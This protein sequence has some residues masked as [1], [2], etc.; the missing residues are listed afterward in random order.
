MGKYF[1]LHILHLHTGKRSSIILINWVQSFEDLPKFENDVFI[2]HLVTGFVSILSQLIITVYLYLLQS[3]PR[4]QTVGQAGSL[5][6]LPVVSETFAGRTLCYHCYTE[7]E[8]LFSWWKIQIPDFQARM[9][10][11][12]SLFTLQLSAGGSFLIWSHKDL[13]SWPLWVWSKLSQPYYTH[14][15]PPDKCS[16]GFQWQLE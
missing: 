10:L 4:T 14:S 6:Q 1:L 9:A 13:Y 2:F 8:D 16:P 7:K 3:K 15:F 11:L 12:T 5:P